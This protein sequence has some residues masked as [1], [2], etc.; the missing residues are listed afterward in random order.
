MRHD[1]TVT[2]W[3]G[4]SRRSLFQSLAAFLMIA[5]STGCGREAAAPVQTEK[6]NEAAN[7][8]AELRKQGKSF[9]EIRSIMRGEAPAKKGKRS[10]HKP[11]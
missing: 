6:Q 9:D 1:P 3:N 2:L 10:A 7:K 5:Q 11:H 4:F 8:I